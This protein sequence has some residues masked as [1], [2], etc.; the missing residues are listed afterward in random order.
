MNKEIIS[1]KI[2]E[3]LD[4]KFKIKFDNDVQKDKYLI[5]YNNFLSEAGTVYLLMQLSIKLG[6]NISYLSEILDQL[7]TFN[8]LVEHI[9]KYY[10]K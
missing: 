1:I 8:N 7:F 2:Q 9:N 10:E 5:N 3:C 6:V 4:E